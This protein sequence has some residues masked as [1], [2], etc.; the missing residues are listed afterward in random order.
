MYFKLLI[1]RYVMHTQLLISTAKFA[2]F[3]LSSLKYFNVS[4]TLKNFMYLQIISSYV[5]INIYMCVCVCVC[6]CSRA[7]DCMYRAVLESKP[8]GNVNIS[9]KT[10]YKISCNEERNIFTRLQMA[11]LGV[12]HPSLPNG[13]L[14]KE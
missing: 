13:E 4:Q 7:G 10:A 12:N 6:V 8:R 2:K 3:L 11:G 5:Y 14:K 9:I 1:C